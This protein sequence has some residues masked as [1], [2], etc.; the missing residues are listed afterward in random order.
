MHNTLLA[1]IYIVRQTT[2]FAVSAA[3]MTIIIDK[4]RMVSVQLLPSSLLYSLAV[5]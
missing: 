4:F 1:Q 5:Q 2:G 3:M